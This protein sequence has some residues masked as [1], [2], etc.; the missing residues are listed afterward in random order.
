MNLKINRFI[1]EVEGIS[2]NTVRY[3]FNKVVVE[4]FHHGRHNQKYGIAL[5]L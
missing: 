4:V 1:L 5:H 2:L 3:L